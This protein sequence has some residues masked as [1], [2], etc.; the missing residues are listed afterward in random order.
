M[1]P[2]FP[3]GRAITNYDNTRSLGSRFRK[4]RIQLLLRAI[5]Y[6]ASRHGQVRIIDIGGMKNYWNIVPR[7]YL[8]ERHVTITI[9]NLAGSRTPQDDE[10][11]KF[12]AADACDLSMFTD[13]SFHIA[14]SNSVIEHV[15]GWP[16]M[17]SFAK[18]CTRV[19][20]HYFIQTPSIWFPIE[21]H[22]MFPFFH[23]LPWPAR[24]WL[25]MHLNIGKWRQVKLLGP[26]VDTVDSVQLLSRSMFSGLFP[27]ATISTER[28]LGFSKSYVATSPD[29]TSEP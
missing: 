8:A 1:T 7:A 28:F 24:V 25:L 4:K 5:D 20:E 3:L 27:E 13:R 12:I 18:E 17:V 26:A 21:P 16:R 22:L 15:G 9:I 10:I 2:P 19:A 29:L 14:H 11:F 6:I 23:W